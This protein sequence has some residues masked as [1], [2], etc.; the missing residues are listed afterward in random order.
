M[1][2][3]RLTRVRPWLVAFAIS[4]AVA[5][6]VLIPPH[7]AG[8]TPNAF[9]LAPLFVFAAIALRLLGFVLGLLARALRA[10]PPDDTA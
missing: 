5:I 6:F 2:L 3:R 4:G 9:S 7:R 10:W 1:G 8:Y